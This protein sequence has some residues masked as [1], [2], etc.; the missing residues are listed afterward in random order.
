[1][2]SRQTMSNWLIY[3]SD[4]W[5]LPVYL[6]LKA[7]EM[8]HDLLHADET[9]LQVLHETNRTAQQKSYMWLYRTAPAA[10]RS[11]LLSCMTMLPDAGRSTP[12]LYRRLL[13]LPWSKRGNARRLLGARPPKI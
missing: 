10:T 3:C 8:K 4:N 12:T 13:R 9:E 7:E 6:A 5:G 2:L 11:I 1:M